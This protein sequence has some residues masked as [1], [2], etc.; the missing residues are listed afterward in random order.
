MKRLFYICLSAVVLMSCQVIKEEDRLIEV[1]NTEPVSR[2]LIAEC[3]GFKCMNCPNAPQTAYTLLKTYSE[4]LVVVE[5]HPKTN[6][7]CQTKKP[8]Y[9]YTCPE[10]DTIY[11]WLGGT[12]T[13][14][15]PTGSVNF[16]TGLVDYLEWPALVRMA[17]VKETIGKIHV[18]VNR[19][20]GRNIEVGWHAE[21]ASS[22]AGDDG[23]TIELQTML[24][25]IEDSIVGPQKMP[26]GST[27]MEYVHNHVLRASVLPHVFGRTDSYIVNQPANDIH[28]LTYMV[29]Q[30]NNGQSIRLE[31]CAIVGVVADPVTREV[32]DVEMVHLAD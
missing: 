2:A 26:D 3:T 8:E 10:A 1:G 19:L 11:T 22:K 25:L 30:M 27:N 32:Y 23:K 9:D 21:A 31:H 16:S 18:Q 4:N 5:L 13:T 14:P 6:T 17:I 28:T 24:W 7:F 15:F 12:S 20:D 29:P